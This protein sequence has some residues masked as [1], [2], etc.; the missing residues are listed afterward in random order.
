[1][2]HPA[3]ALGRIG[4]IGKRPASVDLLTAKTPL[5][6]RQFKRQNTAALLIERSGPQEIVKQRILDDEAKLFFKK[7]GAEEAVEEL[8]AL[9][10][11]I[12]MKSTG[13]HHEEV[14]DGEL[15][16]AQR[17]FVCPF[18]VQ[19]NGDFHE[20]VPVHLNGAIVVLKLRAHRPYRG[21][22]VNPTGQ[23]LRHNAVI[24]S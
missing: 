18:A 19:D 8:Q 10:I 1:M 16:Y 17:R 3:D 13:P 2:R 23:D 20:I 12:I 15:L 4:A 9:A 14:S 22:E 6:R 5:R 11:E 7:L 21:I 24:M